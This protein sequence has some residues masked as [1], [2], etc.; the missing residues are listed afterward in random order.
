M[1]TQILEK[2]NLRDKKNFLIYGIGQAFNL[3]SPLIVAP[4]I[5]RICKVEG[6][7]KVGLGFALSL[8]LILIVDYAFDIKGTKEVSENRNH[9]NELQRIITTTLYTKIVLFFVA[10]LIAALII[11]FIPFFHNEKLLFFYSLTIVLAQVFNPIW[12]LQGLEDFKW[13][14]LINIVSKS[15]Y[16]ILIFNFIVV[17]NDY[18]LVNF[19]L[20]ISSLFCNFIGLVVIKNRF[21]FGITK[22]NF[23]VIKQII[24]NDFLFCV[25]QLF[26]STRQLSPLLLISYFL[27]YSM[28]GQYKI[29]EQLITLYRTFTQVYL[30]YFFPQA[31]YKVKQKLEIGL[32]YWK[33]YVVFNFVMVTASL[34]V[35]YLLSGPILHFFNVSDSNIVHLKPVFKTAL[36]V[37]FLMVLSLSLEQL[38]FITNKNKVYIKITIFVT[39]VNVLLIAILLTHFELIG[40]IAAIAISELLF[41]VLYFNKAYLVLNKKLKN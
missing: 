18:L 3:L 8:F 28:S 6:F 20:G 26:L 25:S 23:T 21:N 36:I 15:I 27:G 31:C 9:A 4:F 14:A 22:P 29:V 7:G 35:M 12:F 5:I 32:N 13:A 19:F 11:Y 33:Q 34:F 17:E 2:L 40:V 16:L 10:L 39:V 30:K 38:M 37:P 24:K 41:I 1:I